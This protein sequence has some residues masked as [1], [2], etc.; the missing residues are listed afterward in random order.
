[1]LEY[2]LVIYIKDHPNYIGNFE[3]CAD[4]TKYIQ[5]CYFNTVMPSDYYVSCQHQDYLFLPKG[6][7]AIYPEDC[8]SK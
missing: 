6:F 4:A 1:M 2:V 7:V 5:Q 3:S 8:T